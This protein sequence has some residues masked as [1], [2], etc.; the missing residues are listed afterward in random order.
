MG[1]RRSAMENDTHPRWTEVMDNELSPTWTTV[2][3]LA[4]LGAGAVGGVLYA[5][6]AFV[7]RGLD[8]VPT[9]SGVMAMQ[10]VN[11]AAPRAPLMIPLVGTALLSLVLLV[12]A[13]PMVRG[14]QPTGWLLAAGAGLY[15]V[16][17]LITAAY[18]V[19]RNDALALLSPGAPG[20]AEAW[21]AYLHE[22]T[23]ANHVRVAA[24]LLSA[25]A[26]VNAVRVA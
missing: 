14:G 5:F 2:I 13:V 21:R 9:A 16:S 25:A 23:T 18:H 20:T 6:S 22:W 10:Q 24:A 3:T 7:M 15:L 26:L 1:L 4:A 19:P 8:R 11:L 12:R 17:F